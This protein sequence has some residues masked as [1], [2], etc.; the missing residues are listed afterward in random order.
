MN[1]RRTLIGAFVALACLGLANLPAAQAA[2][3]LSTQAAAATKYKVVFQV[4][5]PDP[6]KWNLA[7]SNIKNVQEELGRDHV[8]VELVAYGPG[9]AML[10]FDSEVG[11]RVAESIE[12]GVKIVACQNTMKSL[13]LTDADMLPRIQYVKAGVVEIMAKQAQGYQYIR[14]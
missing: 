2:E 6:K 5:D 3:N 8:D 11:D 9:L 1:H 4:S 12:H 7:L 13:K 10:K 14:P